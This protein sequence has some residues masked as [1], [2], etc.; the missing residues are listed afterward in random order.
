VNR[1][2]ETLTEFCRKDTEVVLASQAACQHGHITLK[3]ACNKVSSQSKSTMTI[4]PSRLCR[5][6]SSCPV[7]GMTLKQEGGQVNILWTEHQIQT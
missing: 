3:K 1:S 7:Q 2:E 4:Y 6:S 5:S